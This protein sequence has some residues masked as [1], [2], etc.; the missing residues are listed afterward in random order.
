M[1]LRP[2]SAY[3]VLFVNPPEGPLV[4]GQFRLTI[5]FS[6]QVK[7]AAGIRGRVDGTGSD[8]RLEIN[9]VDQELGLNFLLVGSLDAQGDELRGDWRLVSEMPGIPRGGQ[10]LARRLPKEENSLQRHFTPL[11]RE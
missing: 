2:L 5:A 1:K 9:L 8:D 11:P 3:G 7:I 4:T 10:W 6:S